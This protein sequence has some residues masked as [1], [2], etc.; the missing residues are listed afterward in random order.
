MVIGKELPYRELGF[1]NVEQFIDSIPDTVNLGSGPAG[2]TCFAVTNAET[3]QIARFVALQKKP[4]IKKSMMP[5]AAIIKRPVKMAG[6]SKRSKFGPTNHRRA[7][8]GGRGVGGASRYVPAGYSRRGEGGA[9]SK[10][11]KP[12]YS[13]PSG[14]C[15]SILCIPCTQYTSQH[16]LCNSTALCRLVVRGNSE[17]VQCVVYSTT[18]FPFSIV[19]NCY[20]RYILTPPALDNQP[21]NGS[22]Y[23]NVNCVK[24]GIN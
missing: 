11:G 18:S 20:F 1:R 23:Y 16:L 17:K 19:S 4:S 7:G 10:L 12:V 21:A 9:M 6:F 13:K 3:R 14:M 5:P 2:L 15:I 8:G 22:M 24:Y